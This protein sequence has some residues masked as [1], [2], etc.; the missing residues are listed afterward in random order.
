MIPKSD[1]LEVIPDS[2]ISDLKTVSFFPTRE[3]LV[4]AQDRYLFLHGW[5][6]AWNDSHISERISN[7]IVK[8]GV[9]FENFCKVW[10]A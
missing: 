7:E 9:T 2:L 10:G 5:A 3:T 8:R 6:D 4:L 1:L